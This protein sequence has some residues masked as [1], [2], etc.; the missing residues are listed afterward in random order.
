MKMK[1]I[2]II[3]L[4]IIFLG[5]TFKPKKFPNFEYTTISSE[6]VNNK[7]FN[8]NRSVVIIGHIG[9]PPLMQFIKDTQES[10]VDDSFQLIY[11]LENT[12]NQIIDFNSDE[13]N[14]WAETRR[15][16]GIK[17]LDQILIGEC[18]NE[19][20]KYQGDNIIVASQCRNLSRKLNT[21]S[22][23]SF[24]F[25][26]ENG[27]IQKTKKGYLSGLNADERLEIVLNRR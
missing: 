12:N 4:S 9:C 1:T 20:L 8:N 5:A 10:K 19:K 11:I 24:Y 26:D 23:P 27:L 25:I 22:S 13:M 17:P 3:V 2:R 7:V 16:F 21:R 18:R 6:I 14:L 15:A